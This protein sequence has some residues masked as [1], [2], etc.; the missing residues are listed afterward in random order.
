MRE[1]TP[2]LLMEQVVMILVFALAAAVCLK[3]FALSYE[4]SRESEAKDRA[5]IAAQNAAELMKHHGGSAEEALQ[6]AAAELGGKISGKSCYINYDE[7]WNTADSQ[8]AY[9]L[10]ATTADTTDGL[11]GVEIRV[12]DCGETGTESLFSLTVLWQE[13]DYGG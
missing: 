11:A 5:A 1:K 12:L 8:A 3:A 4:I 10:E 9:L 6:A 13:V 7:G 2:L